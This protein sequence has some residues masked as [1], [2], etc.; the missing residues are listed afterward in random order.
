MPASHVPA[1]KRI[2]QYLKGTKDKGLIMHSSKQLYVNCYPNADFACLYNHED[3]QDPHC[4][5]SPT[6]YVILLAGCPVL[7][8]SK[9]QTEIALSAMEAK[10]VALSQSCSGL[11]PLLDQVKELGDAIGLP[12]DAITN[13]HIQIHADNVGALVLGQLEP[14]R[15]TPRSK[16]YAIKCH[17][18]C[19]HIGPHNIKLAIPTNDQLDDLFTK[20]LGTLPLLFEIK[21]HGLVIPWHLLERERDDEMSGD[22][23]EGSNYE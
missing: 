9:L 8:K 15:M 23:T 5:W 11:F 14:K 10:Y 2:G 6:G 3:S 13:L 18:F 1:L 4:V 7:W 20:G 19:E 17:W 21:A 12:V 16:H 22:T